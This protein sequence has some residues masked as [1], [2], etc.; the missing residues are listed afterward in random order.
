MLGWTSLLLVPTIVIA[1]IIMMRFMIQRQASYPPNAVYQLAFIDTVTLFGFTVLYLM[2][3]YFR[4][5]LKL[6]ARFMVATIFGP[7]VP[8]LTRM[9]IFNLGLASGFNDGLTYSYLLIEL[10]L[11]IIIWKERNEKEIYLTYVPFFLFIVIQHVVMY[12]AGNWG[13][14][15]SVMDAF[16][17]YS[18]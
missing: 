6:H 8:A 18:S 1:G 17:N 10:V 9:F 5:N 11:L 16:A 7:L 15:K 4:K 14:W 2:A 3:L 12:F 13:W